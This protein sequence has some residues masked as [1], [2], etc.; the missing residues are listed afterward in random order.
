MKNRLIVIAS[1]VA[2]FLLTAQDGKSTFTVRDIQ[3]VTDIR[4]LDVSSYRASLM[5][6]LKSAASKTLLE[7]TSLA[8]PRIVVEGTISRSG[9]LTKLIIISQSGSGTK[10]LIQEAAA[11]LGS[12][13]FPPLPENFVGEKLS[14]LFIVTN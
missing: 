4:G 10:R 9:K 14:A 7:K 2:S 8:D 13:T 5:S 6:T 1:L 11:T 12:V 3:L